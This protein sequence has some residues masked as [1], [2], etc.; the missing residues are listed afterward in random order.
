[1]VDEKEK[2]RTPKTAE[3]PVEA[4]C[5]LAMIKYNGRL[6]SVD[7]SSIHH[8]GQDLIDERF[9]AGADACGGSWQLARRG[10]HC[11]ARALFCLLFPSSQ[12]LE[13]M[14]AGRV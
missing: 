2:L 10:L 13:N 11:G 9:G 12:A 5:A 1:M 4:R 8:T 7:G 14:P 3:K 6:I